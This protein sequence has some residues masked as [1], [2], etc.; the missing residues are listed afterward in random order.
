MGKSLVSIGGLALLIATVPAGATT[1]TVNS[2]LDLPDADPTDGACATAPPNPVCTLRA[3]VMQANASAGEDTVVLSNTTYLLTLAGYDQT[4]ALG[5]L[6]VTDKLIIQGNGATIDANGANTADRAFEVLS[7]AGRLWLQDLTIRN[8][9]TPSYGGAIYAN[10]YLRLDDVDVVSNSASLDGGGIYATDDLTVNSSLIADNTSQGSQGGGIA[11]HDGGTK[12]LQLSAAEIARN[13]VLGASGSGG[14]IAG[15]EALTFIDHTSVHDNS[16]ADRGGGLFYHYSAFAGVNLVLDTSVFD[17]NSSTIGG[18]LYVDGN[19]QIHTTTVSRGSANIGGGIYATN[20][21]HELTD[22]GVSANESAG[23]GGGIF[24]G[25][26]S[27]D[28]L[29]GSID[30]NIAAASGGGIA[31]TAIDAQSLTITDASVHDNRATQ[32]G[33]GTWSDIATTIRTSAVY[34]N[35]GARGGGVYSNAGLD[36]DASILDGNAAGSYGGGAYLDS[37]ARARFSS[38]TISGNASRASYP[39]AGTGSGLY[40]DPGALADART[41][42]FAYNNNSPQTIAPNDCYGTLSVS[43]YV[44]LSTN[45]SCTTTIVSGTGNHIGGTYPN[46]IDPLLGTLQP[47]YDPLLPPSPTAHAKFGRAPLSGSILINGGPVVCYAS[48]GSNLA[49]DEIGQVRNLGGNC[50]IGAIEYGAGPDRIFVG[51]FDA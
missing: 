21:T 34:K 40:I 44:F 15:D 1:Y 6:D 41:S 5:D 13:H 18:N 29:R 36:F 7:G 20:G 28:F 9:A 27:L 48:D 10:A 32:D 45:A 8:G 4:A 31:A 49:S 24:V 17:H 46:T 12:A 37:N 30:H 11:L 47:L 22:V 39:K 23:S 26:G 3:A 50:D 16:S 14:G 19:D 33:G 35:R 25:Y 51:P 38:A 43:G 2:T 42:V